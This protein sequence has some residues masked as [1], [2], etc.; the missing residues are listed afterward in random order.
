M[1]ISIEDLIM[2]IVF[3]TFGLITYIFALRY[4]LKETKKELWKE[5]DKRWFM[6][7]LQELLAFAVIGCI[8]YTIAGAFKYLT[9]KELSSK[10]V[11]EAK[12]EVQNKILNSKTANYLASGLFTKDE[13]ESMNNKE[14]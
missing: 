12:K 7:I 9:G 13:L 10:T 14:E 6:E 1:Y 4:Q 8:L 5:R 3:P 2:F 11:D